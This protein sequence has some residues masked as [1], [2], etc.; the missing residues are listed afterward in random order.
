MNPGIS[1]TVQ[2]RIALTGLLVALLISF[3]WRQA[4]GQTPSPEAATGMD[5]AVALLTE[6]R[7]R[8]QN[9]RDYECRLLKRERVK[10]T[11]LPES[12][13]EMKVRNNPFS[14]YLRCESPKDD[15]GLEI[16][17]VA[18]RD[19]GMM[20]VQ[21]NGLLGIIGF[22]SI[23]PRDSRAFEKNRH[24]ITE[25][26]IG[27]LLEST[28]RYW[29]MERRLNKT[30]VHVTNDGLGGRTCTRIETI[31]P[32]RNA[33]AFYGYRCVLWL[34][35]KT[36]LPAGAAT[37]DWP[38]PAGPEGGDLLEWYRYS[39]LRCNVGLGDDAFPR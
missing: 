37:Y 25:A 2:A 22:V 1:P 29:D 10:G 32:D 7:L 6:A 15:K 19:H 33:G 5:Q 24:C 31:H 12:E 17:Y 20:R 16:C 8:F 35:N 38:R 3:A 18:G 14:V 34:D 30:L 4:R 36:H 23:D 39:D 21:P 9:V 11:L 26:G 13:F 28:A 27:N